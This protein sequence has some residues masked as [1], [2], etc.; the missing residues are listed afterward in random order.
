MNIK[1]NITLSVCSSTFKKDPVSSELGKR[2]LRGAIDLIDE[3][4]LEAFTFRKLALKVSSTEASVYR[5]F[6]SKYHLMGYLVSWYWSWMQ[7]RLTLK[8]A[9]IEDPMD[10]LS[11]TITMLT[12]K[13]EEDS[14]FLFINEVKL[15]KIVVAESSKLILH[16]NVD[17]SNE[18]GFFVD[19]KKFVQIV[20]DIVLEYNPSYK[21]PHMLTSTI[22]EGVHF[23]YFFTEHLPK[24]T[25]VIEGEN[26]IE[27]FY[28]EMLFNLIQKK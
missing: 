18:Q 10:K 27:T 22:I 26:S 28:K 11:R 12:E 13:I 19:Y 24:L 21:Y 20:S 1:T 17:E 9:N 6:E 7:Y 14:D 8:L 3:V 4:G 5:Y 2:I 16:K 25:D 15:S 23:Q